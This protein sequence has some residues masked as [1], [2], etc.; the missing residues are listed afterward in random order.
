MA[1]GRPREFDIDDA[2]DAAMRVF[3][4]KGYAGASLPDLTRAMGISAPSLYAAF[5]SKEGLYRRVLARYDDGP[6]R[7]MSEALEAPTAR[8]VV[9]RMLRAAAELQTD[10][11]WPRGCLMVRG[12]GSCG[13]ERA[14]PLRR[15]IVARLNGGERAL[16]KRLERAR[17]ERDL[18]PDADPAQLARWVATVKYGMAVQAAGGASRKQL[19]Q[20]VDLMLLAWPGAPQRARVARRRGRPR[21]G[22]RQA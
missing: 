5:G 12:E 20:V 22:R 16:R 14:D 19:D 18:P 11:R 9:E 8:A 1:G 17:S 15:E 2:L 13:G 4:R 3:W 21:P 10:P 7:F 6:A